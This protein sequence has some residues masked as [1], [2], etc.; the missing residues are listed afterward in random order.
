VVGLLYNS[1]FEIKILSTVFVLISRSGYNGSTMTDQTKPLQ[2]KRARGLLILTA[3]LALFQFGAAVRAVQ[4]PDDLAARVNLPLPLEF[5]ASLLWAA[6]ALG[7]FVMLWTGRRQARLF[8]AWLAVGFSIYSLLRLL[9]F[10][11]A[12]YDRGRFPFLLIVIAILLFTPV[13]YLA[14]YRRTNLSRDG[15]I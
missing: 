5:I 10:S 11:Q 2:R 3:L 1:R 9:L 4:I 15:D 6:A 7:V 13:A 14:R 8:A 12:D